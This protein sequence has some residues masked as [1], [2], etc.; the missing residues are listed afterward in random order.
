MTFDTSF[1]SLDGLRVQACIAVQHLGHGNLSVHD[2][3]RVKKRRLSFCSICMRNEPIGLTHVYSVL[4]IGIVSPHQSFVFQKDAKRLCQKRAREGAT[5]ATASPSSPS[6]SALAFA[7]ASFSC[8]TLI[9]LVGCRVV[10]L[11]SR[12]PSFL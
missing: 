12:A 6:P 2:S 3:N 7:S 5:I 4:L 1:E 11:Q 9:V 8:A 10:L